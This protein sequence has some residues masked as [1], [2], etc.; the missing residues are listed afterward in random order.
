MSASL[1]KGK[2]ID[3]GTWSCKQKHF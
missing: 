2:P 1:K 3:T